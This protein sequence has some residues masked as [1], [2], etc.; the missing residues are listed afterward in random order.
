MPVNSAWTRIMETGRASSPLGTAG[1]PGM[2]PRRSRRWLK[3][4]TL[5]STCRSIWVIP[6]CLEVVGAFVRGEAFENRANRVPQA[7][8]ARDKKMRRPFGPAHLQDDIA[9]K[10]NWS[11]FSALKVVSADWVLIELPSLMVIVPRFGTSKVEPTSF[12]ALPAFRSTARC[13]ASQ[14]SL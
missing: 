8:N 14:P 12:L 11:M 7:G 3:K 13:A 6:C 2:E 9:Q 5:E 10:S 1:T 4:A